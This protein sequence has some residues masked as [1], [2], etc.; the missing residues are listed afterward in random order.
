MRRR[1]LSLLGSVLLLTVSCARKHDAP[2]TKPSAS[3][4]TAPKVP[5][6]PPPPNAEVIARKFV[7]CWEAFGRDAFAELA[8]CY[9]DAAVSRWIDSE[10]PDETGR[11]NIVEKR[12]QGFKAAFP[13]A[14]VAPQIVLVNGFDVAA[15]GVL[16]GTQKG[17]FVSGARR[18]EPTKLAM[19]QL[20]FS[21]ARFDQ[22]LLVREESLLSDRAS[23]L[24]Q[25]GASPRRARPRNTQGLVNAPVIVTATGDATERANVELVAKRW[26]AFSAEDGPALA[27]SFADDVVL[28]DQLLPDD[29][30]GKAA[31]LKA[32]D[33]L[34]AAFSAIRVSCPT[35][36]AA[37]TYVASVCRFD[38]TNDGAF[39]GT[40]PSNRR[41]AF[42]IAEIA[43]LEG[44][45][46]REI[47]RFADGARVLSEMGVETAG[48]STP[49]KVTP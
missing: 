6:P 33:T 25:L 38:A 46:A 23:M 5:P 2:A 15:T 19:G 42:T 8:D 13:D 27:A 29:A 22:A 24:F 48:K 16:S 4:P 45:L 9:A 3:V 32:T 30:R 7:G 14:K 36:F 35:R 43:R 31:A 21:G 34:L 44:G 1:V 40:P 17:P 28:V 47:V 18:L 12:K 26:Q 39:L 49:A 41:V 11:A 20:V 10:F 37:G